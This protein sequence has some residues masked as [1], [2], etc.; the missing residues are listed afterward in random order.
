MNGDIELQ[1]DYKKWKDGINYKTNRKI[2][3]GG[4][5]HRE[6]KQK[7]MISY[8]HNYSMWSQTR[9]S[10]LFEDL[11]NINADDYLQETKKINNEI[12][13]ENIIIKNYN[14]VL[15]RQHLP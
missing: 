11:I 10:V 9:S 3:I 8:S 5:I 4:K 6:L 1:N 7:F 13:A 2:K 14:A 12:D 15:L